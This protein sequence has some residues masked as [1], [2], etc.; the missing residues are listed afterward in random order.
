MSAYTLYFAFTER[1]DT[2]G[3]T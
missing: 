3:S 2:T 1:V